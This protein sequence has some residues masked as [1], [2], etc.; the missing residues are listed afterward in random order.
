MSNEKIVERRQ[1]MIGDVLCVQVPPGEKIFDISSGVEVLLGTVY[2]GHPVINAGAQTCYLST[3]DFNA[4]EAVL[5]K[6]PGV[7]LQ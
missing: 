5:P 6:A 1:A 3:N 2:D 4:A 7:L